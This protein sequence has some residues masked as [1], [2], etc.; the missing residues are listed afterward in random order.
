MA[1]SEGDPQTGEQVSIRIEGFDTWLP[2][3]VPVHAPRDSRASTTRAVPVVGCFVHDRFVLSWADMRCRSS[4]G[5]SFPAECDGAGQRN[6]AIQDTAAAISFVES[7]M[8][9]GRRE[10]DL[11]D[12]G[13]V[14]GETI[15][16]M[17]PPSPSPPPIFT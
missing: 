15:A 3:L 9:E 10:L 14:E 6:V 1:K 2:A 13:E 5:A 4:T 17:L 16:I 8:Q 11:G 12:Y 7:L